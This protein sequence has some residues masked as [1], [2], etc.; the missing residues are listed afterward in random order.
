ML[1]VVVGMSEV[2]GWERWGRDGLRWPRGRQ[3]E[4]V[5]TR[6]DHGE[7]LPP[8]GKLAGGHEMDLP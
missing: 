7:T 8:Y 1:S 2:G 5:C 3:G 6:Q 4:K